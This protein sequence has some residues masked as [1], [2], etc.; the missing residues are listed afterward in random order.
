MF[1]Y[2]PT[3]LCFVSHLFL[4]VARVAQWTDILTISK[5]N[6]AGFFSGHALD[7]TKHAS[8]CKTKPNPFLYQ[9]KVAQR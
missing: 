3:D 7:E 4:S 2:P 5:H 1:L 6:K 9:Q 8:A